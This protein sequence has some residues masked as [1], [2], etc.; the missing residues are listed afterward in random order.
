[1]PM[2][3]HP[4]TGVPINSIETRSGPISTAER[5]TARLLLDEGHARWVVAAMLGRF[6]LAFDRGGRAPERKSR[7]KI[8]GGE[9]PLGAAKQDPRQISMD[10]FWADLFGADQA[11]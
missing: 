11:D 5:Q 6:P 10:D 7:R 3:P 1:M 4:T 9:L 8:A 2:T